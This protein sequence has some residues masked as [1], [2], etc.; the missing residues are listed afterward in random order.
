MNVLFVCTGNVARSPMAAA[1]F[2]EL[3]GRDARHAAR[4]AGTDAGAAR[5]LTTRD[6]AWA[7]VVAVM[8]AG[9]RE[10]IRRQWPEHA[11]KVR[12]LHVPDDY[13]P[14]ERELR[15]VLTPK[16]EGLVRELDSAGAPSR[17]RPGHR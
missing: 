17:K 12:V 6:L 9:H 13:D 3:L 11:P 14:G 7:E 1:I 16:I 8:E 5:R 2:R 10:V 15:E 4:T